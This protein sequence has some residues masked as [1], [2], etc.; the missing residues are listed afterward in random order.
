MVRNYMGVSMTSSFMAYWLAIG[1]ECISG[2]AFYLLPLYNHVHCLLAVFFV[3][4]EWLKK[5][6]QNFNVSLK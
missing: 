4:L 3:M 1:K 2:R 5:F 6:L